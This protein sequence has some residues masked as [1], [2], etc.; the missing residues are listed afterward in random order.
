VSFTA[1]NA[2]EGAASTTMPATAVSARLAVDAKPAGMVSLD[3]GLAPNPVR[4][5]SW[6]TFLTTRE[7]P[8]TVG[9][10]DLLGRRVRELLNMANAPATLH[11]IPMNGLSDE[12]EP[13]PSGVYFLRVRAVEGVATERVLIPR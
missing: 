7:G 12:D 6:L 4:P 5:D 13:L 1:A 10:Y 3:R 2:R 8:L 9:L 11:Q